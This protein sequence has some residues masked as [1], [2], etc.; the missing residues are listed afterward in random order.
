MCDFSNVPLEIPMFDLLFAE[1]QSHLLC[2]T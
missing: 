1:T 2:S